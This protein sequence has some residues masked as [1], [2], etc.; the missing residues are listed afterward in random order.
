MLL[1]DA[2][3]ALRRGLIL[4]LGLSAGLLIVVVLTALALVPAE[5]EALNRASS[6]PFSAPAVVS[7]APQMA[8]APSSDRSAASSA[9]SPLAD[10]MRSV[11]ESERLEGKSLEILVQRP[12][13]STEPTGEAGIKAGEES[14]KSGAQLPKLPKGPH[15]QAGIFASPANAEEMKKKLEAE[16]YPAYVETRVHVGP[17]Q[18]RKDADKARE[19]L[20][21]QGTVTLFI[22]Q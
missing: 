11:S 13:E 3:P 6:Q 1:P 5:R 7:P 18:N 8:V 10:A 12:A 4:R 14:Q 22:P 2:Y 19:K 21:E 15:L 9:A 16:G 17:F 20:K